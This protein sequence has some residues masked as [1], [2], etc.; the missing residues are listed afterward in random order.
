M[1]ISKI[2]QN[3]FHNPSLNFKSLNQN[4]LHKKNNGLEQIFK[5]S[6]RNTPRNLIALLCTNIV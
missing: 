6:P 1:I 5:E 3:K 2:K 4:S